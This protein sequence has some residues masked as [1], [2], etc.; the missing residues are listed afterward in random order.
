MPLFVY[1]PEQNKCLSLYRFA[2]KFADLEEVVIG[3]DCLLIKRFFQQFLCDPVY[4]N[5][6]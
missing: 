1:F 6:P 4:Y 5:I 3:T 2:Y